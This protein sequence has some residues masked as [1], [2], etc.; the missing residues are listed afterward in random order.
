MNM[1]APRTWGYMTVRTSLKVISR[2]PRRLNIWP[3]IAP[4]PAAIDVLP[5]AWPPPLSLPME[6]RPNDDDASP[7]LPLFP[8]EN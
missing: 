5:L 4:A 3:Y 2:L 7:P 8:S 6:D 1:R